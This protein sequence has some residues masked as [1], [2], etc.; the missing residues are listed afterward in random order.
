MNPLVP[1]SLHSPGD[2]AGVDAVCLDWH[3]RRHPFHVPSIDAHHPN[4][5]SDQAMVERR[6]QRPRLH[7]DQLNRQTHLLQERGDRLRLRRHLPLLHHLAFSSTTQT[8]VSFNDMSQPNKAIHVSPPISQFAEGHYPL[9]TAAWK[10]IDLA[11]QAPTKSDPISSSLGDRR[12]EERSPSK[13]SVPQVQFAKLSDLGS[14]SFAFASGLAPKV[15]DVSTRGWSRD[16]VMRTTGG[17]SSSLPV[18]GLR[19]RRQRGAE[20]AG[21]RRNSTISGRP[22]AIPHSAERRS[23]ARH[24]AE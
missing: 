20:Q 11:S 12:F 9:V 10:T 8:D 6:S 23:R 4:V 1:A 17:T 16:A 5:Q 18:S 7:A 13:N 22:V 21:T 19:Q 14:N 2:V 3:H 15:P 24:R